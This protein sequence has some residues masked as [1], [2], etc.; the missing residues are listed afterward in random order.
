MR[1]N[2]WSLSINV[3][4]LPPSCRIAGTEEYFHFI[5]LLQAA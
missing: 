2:E 4:V 5:W 1:K 3:G